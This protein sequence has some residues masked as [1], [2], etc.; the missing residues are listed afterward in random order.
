[1]K[2]PERSD[3]KP[4]IEQEHS[5]EATSTKRVREALLIVAL[6]VGG[7]LLRDSED[8]AETKLQNALDIDS[9]KNKFDFNVQVPGKRYAIHLGQVH[10]QDTFEKMADPFVR[11]NIIR[12]Q[13]DVEQALLVLKDKYQIDAVYEEGY[14]PENEGLR[15]INAWFEQL[16]KDRGAGG[17]PWAAARI[18]EWA[19]KFRAD[20]DRINQYAKTMFL[21][22]F[23]CRSRELLEADTVKTLDPQTRAA[24]QNL[25]DECQ[26]D[27]LIAGDNI[28]LWGSSQKLWLEGKF[29]LRTTE[30]QKIM[31]RAQQIAAAISVKQKAGQ[32]VEEKLIKDFVGVQNEREDL[33][34]ERALT[35]FSNDIK[36]PAVIVFGHAHDFSGNLKR[37]LEAGQTKDTGIIKL[38]NKGDNVFFKILEAKDPRF[39]APNLED[40]KQR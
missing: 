13:K 7:T 26:R 5:Q 10:G 30:D 2:S 36:K 27:P 9:L 14:A 35:D 17:E 31:E 4:T 18:L 22:F 25:A 23:V 37:M 11:V 39:K 16:K 12:S 28:Y 21:Y 6:G 24:I 33:A 8:S 32:P 15:I 19:E 40:P 29:S 20:R 38:E 3:S 1:M 34:L